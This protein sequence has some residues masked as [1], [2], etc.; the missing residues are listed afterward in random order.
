MNETKQELVSLEEARKISSGK[1]VAESDN[2][3]DRVL[4]LEKKAKNLDRQSTFIMWV[5]GV[6][7]IGFLFTIVLISL[8]Y[9]RYNGERYE[10]LMKETRS[11]RDT[12]LSKEDGRVM[13]E[14]INKDTQVLDCFKSKGYFSITCY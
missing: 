9:S 11:I 5:A 14:K 3:R 1:D 6:V 12:F 10:N 4:D 13:G 7:M 2:L 8:D